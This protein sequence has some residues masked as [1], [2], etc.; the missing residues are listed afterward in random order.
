MATVLVGMK[1]GTSKK[2]SPY[3][4]IHIV[5]DY[6]DVEKANGAC[7]SCVETVF[8]PDVL[9]K[10]ISAKDVG[11]KVNIGYSV[12]AGR[13]SVASIEVLGK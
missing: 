3:T 8:L 13:A 5:Q 6:S 11:K 12:F 1:S 9:A 10:Q 7:G 4:M 2:G